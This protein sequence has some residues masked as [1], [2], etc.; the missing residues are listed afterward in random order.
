MRATTNVLCRNGS[1]APGDLWRYCTTC[2]GRKARSRK[3]CYKCKHPWASVH[4]R[5]KVV[6]VNRG[7]FNYETVKALDTPRFRCSECGDTSTIMNDYP[8]HKNGCS[9]IGQKYAEVP[10]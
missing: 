6:V 2:G 8:H 3:R 1:F 9:R 10:R 7:G 5:S 4:D